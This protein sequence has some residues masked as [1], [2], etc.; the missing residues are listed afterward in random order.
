[1]LPEKTEGGPLFAGR[2]YNPAWFFARPDEVSFNTISHDETFSVAKVYVSDLVHFYR[3][4][5]S[6]NCFG[7][8]PHYVWM[9]DAH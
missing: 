8:I 3:P 2:K 1:M 9:F 5:Q 7:I 4:S 6:L